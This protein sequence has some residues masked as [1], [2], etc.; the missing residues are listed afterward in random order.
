MKN[1]EK[2]I[3]WEEIKQV[4]YLHQTDRIL[5]FGTK[6]WPILE[7]KLMHF[8]EKEI[9]QILRIVASRIGKKVELNYW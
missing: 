9:E 7:A 6:P 1:F 2:T 3:L 4:K 8:K 5:F